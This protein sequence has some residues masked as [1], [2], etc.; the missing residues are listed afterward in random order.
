MA[1]QGVFVVIEG[2]DGSGKGTQH[3]LLLERL[4]KLGKNV[5]AVDFPRYGEP[6]AYFVEK[7]LNGGYGASQDT[8]PRRA[9]LFYALDRFDA[10]SGIKETL[11]AGGM[12]VANRYMASNMGHQGAKIKDKEER[13]AFFKWIHDLEYVLLGI[14]KPTLNI[15]LHVPA[16]TAYELVEK[17]S[18]RKYLKGG[19]RDIHEADMDHLIRAEET[20][21]EIARLFPGE[22][23]KIECVPEG[24]MLSV[25]TIHELIWAEIKKLL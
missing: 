18:E 9:S 19:T 12:V 11:A 1:A 21:K 23:L 24:R 8:S 20:Y 5:K 17:K 13:L 6:S 15:L 3:G 4:S 10:S 14:P 22:F 16:K 25:E 2:T 7:Y